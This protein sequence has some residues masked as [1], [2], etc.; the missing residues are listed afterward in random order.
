MNKKAGSMAN[1]VKSLSIVISFLCTN[2]YAENFTPAPITDPHYTKA[3][4]FDIHVCNWP[5]RKL[6]FMALF[7]TYKYDDVSKI[8]IYN[9]EDLKLGEI[10]TDKYKL[11]YQKGKPEKRV[12]IKQIQIQ[13]NAIN[14]WYR[15]I[16]TM[17]S[18]MKYEAKDYVVI[19]NLAQAKNLTPEA[20]S[21]LSK[22]PK[23]LTWNKIPGAKFYKVFIKDYWTQKTLYTSSLLNKPELILPKG[24]IKKRGEYQWVI[25]ARDVNENVLLGDF[26]HG[27]VSKPVSFS[28]N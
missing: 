28:I 1:F 19:A 5:K 15:S 13:Q 12:F 21:E 20:D 6:F 27:S 10:T 2:S 22:I 14:G 25:H 17:K 18:G 24:L 4:F 26:N 9:P 3:G 23:K 11:L 8:E 16:I 7:S